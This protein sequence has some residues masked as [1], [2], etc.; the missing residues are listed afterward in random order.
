[1]SIRRLSCA[2][3]SAL[4]A[5]VLLAAACGD[6]IHPAEAYPNTCDE[7]CVI[8]VFKDLSK[9]YRPSYGE[10]A[11]RVWVQQQVAT[12]IELG[13]WKPEE[14]G[15]DMDESVDAANHM[16]KNVLV[17]VP[18][19]GRHAGLSPVALQAHLDMIFAVDGA[20]SGQPLDDYFRSGVDVVEDA[21][22]LHSRDYKTTLGA[23]CGAGVAQMVR[24]L[25][26]RNLP[27]P[28]LE[29]MFTAAEETGLVGAA[30]WDAS[31]LP[32]AATA[33][34]NL[35]GWSAT[36]LVKAD[37]RAPLAIQLG[38]AGGVVASVDGKLDGSA[39]AADAQLVKLS[40]SGLLGGHS[41]F[42]IGRPRMNAIIA[43][44]A[45]TQEALKLD[46]GL[47]LVSINSGQVSARL[48]HNKIPSAF[49]AVL[50][51]SSTTSVSDLN[52][53]LQTFF[54]S[55]IVPFTDESLATAK[56]VVAAAAGLAP[57]ALT[58]AATK[59]FV[60]TLRTI[61]NG[62]I[63]A[64][65]GSLGGWTV[66]SN[67]GVLG[68]NDGTAGKAVFFGYLP[69][70]FVIE[71]SQLVADQI[72]AEIQQAGL[73]SLTQSRVTAPAWLIDRTA[74]IVT[75][76]KAGAG[77][78][79]DMVLP[80]GTEPGALL[81]KFPQLKDRVIAIAPAIVEAHTPK[82]ALDT[83]SF[84]DATAALQQILVALGDDGAF[85]H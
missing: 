55:Y 2:L 14:I 80:A 61:P 73:S 45:L 23:D 74:A 58:A 11:A 48:G 81:G 17:R 34:I 47:R 41:G 63:E 25:F 71:K 49:E 70:S 6:S 54:A 77:I 36:D 19:T 22:V 15:V 79:R 72:Y 21:G 75:L 46:A 78:D 50:A 28:P 64:D 35:D 32:L 60:D 33:L 12:A 8:D 44:A 13:V 10:E 4:A 42:L 84:K 56:L 52:T 85:L 43:F 7:A 27:H 76:A 37:L 3:S 1:M 39:V 65:P 38:A 51:V 53:A 18:G 68:V 29:L 31:K 9:V 16:I 24:Y 67:I 62:V 30:R 82:E 20:V 57:T 83:Q 40:L 59:T 26:D 66:S 5:F 69:R